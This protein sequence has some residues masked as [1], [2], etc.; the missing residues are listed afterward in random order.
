MLKLLSIKSRHSEYDGSY[1]DYNLSR[2]RTLRFANE[3]NGM[4]ALL[5]LIYFYLFL[6]TFHV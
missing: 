5:T 6:H 2:Q 4:R 3:C 1:F